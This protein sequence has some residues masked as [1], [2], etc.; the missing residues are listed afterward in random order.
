[1]GASRAEIAV[2]AAM[3]AA[4]VKALLSVGVAGAG[5]PKLAVGDVVRAGVVIDG[6]FG[7]FR[8]VPAG[9][10]GKEPVHLAVKADGFDDVRP[11]GLE[12]AAEVVQF[13]A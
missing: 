6:H 3:A 12:G 11:V 8:A 10:D 1:M 9:I 7:D 2:R 4:P 13:D 5:D